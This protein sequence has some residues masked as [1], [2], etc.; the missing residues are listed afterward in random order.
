MML[1]VPPSCATDPAYD[2]LIQDRG[3]GSTEVGRP[4][5]SELR[6]RSSI[7]PPLR[8]TWMRCERGSVV[9]VLPITVRNWTHLGGTEWLV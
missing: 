3:I 9:V 7:W 8:P 5:Y 2:E 1:P 4:F 6:A